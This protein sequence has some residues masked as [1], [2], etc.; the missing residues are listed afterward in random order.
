ME[1]PTPDKGLRLKSLD[2]WLAP[3]RQ[4]V[5]EISIGG[6][7]DDGTITANLKATIERDLFVW[8]KDPATGEMVRTNEVVDLPYDTLNLAGINGPGEICSSL[9]VEMYR[10]AGHPLFGLFDTDE[11]L[12][13]SP[14]EVYR[15]L[16]LLGYVD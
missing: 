13:Y 6:L 15:R 9:I 2:E 14:S 7:I 4:S 16:K 3:Y 12:Q 5:C 1:G 8:E 10:R 11:Q